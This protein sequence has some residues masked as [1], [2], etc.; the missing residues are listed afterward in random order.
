MGRGLCVCVCGGH[1]LPVSRGMA[2]VM[3]CGLSVVGVVCLRQGRGLCH[4]AWSASGAWSMSWGVVCLCRRVWSVP[5]GMVY[6]VCL[7]CGA[8]SVSGAWSACVA[9]CGLC[10]GAWSMSWGVV[11]LHQGRGLCRGA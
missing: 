3:G 6:V 10:H 8:W 9:G 11:C 5:W 1:G 4:E 2:Y 7:C